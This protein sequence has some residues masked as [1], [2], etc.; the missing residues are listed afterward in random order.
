MTEI[1]DAAARLLTP[2]ELQARLLEMSG[3][4]DTALT[5]YRRAVKAH[6][7]ADRQR[8]IAV[9]T[10]LLSVEGKSAPERRAKAEQASEEHIYAEELADGYRDVAKEALRARLAQLSALQSMATT[11]REEMRLSR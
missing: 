1:D 4:V 10:A 9:N 8:R 11:I 7:E 2:H 5:E 3:Q 6:V